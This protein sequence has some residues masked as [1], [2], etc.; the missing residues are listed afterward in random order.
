MAHHTMKF[1]LLFMI[2]F[3][4]VDK[5]SGQNYLRAKLLSFQGEPTDMILNDSISFFSKDTIKI[6][7]S[8]DKSKEYGQTK[9]SFNENK[10]NYDATF[11][12]LYSIKIDTVP[13]VV[14]YFED[15]DDDDSFDSSIVRNTPPPQTKTRV[16]KRIVESGK[17][18]EGKWRL[19]QEILTLYIGTT[20]INYRIITKDKLTLL[21]RKK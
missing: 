10:Q 13:T 19:H 3:S 11:N 20:E 9:I 21:I 1:F 17:Y 5:S 8:I 16:E 12:I 15:V 6:F 7:P 18:I 14:T 4:S 2:I